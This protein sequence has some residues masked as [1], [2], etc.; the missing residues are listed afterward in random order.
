MVNTA[1]SSGAPTSCSGLNRVGKLFTFSS[2]MPGNDEC[3][4]RIR[5]QYCGI[6]YGKQRRRIYDDIIEIRTQLA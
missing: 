4:V 3:A 6:S 1:P 2:S 5:R